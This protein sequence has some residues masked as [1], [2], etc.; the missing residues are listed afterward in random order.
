MLSINMTPIILYIALLPL[1]Y[2]ATYYLGKVFTYIMDKL[3]NI[4]KKI[5][6]RK[7]KIDY[8]NEN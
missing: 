6:A 5:V 3:V 8:G 4:C 1:I 2:I 7:E